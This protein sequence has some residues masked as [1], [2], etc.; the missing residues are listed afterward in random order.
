MPR[1]AQTPC[2]LTPTRGLFSTLALSC[3][4]LLLGCPL[5][6]RPLA[7]GSGPDAQVDSTASPGG[8]SGNQPDGGD[9]SGSASNVDDSGSEASAGEPGDAGQAPTLVDGCADLDGDGVADCQEGLAQNP[10]FESDTADWVADASTTLTWDSRNAW[11][12]VPSG[13]ALVAASGVIDADANGAALHAASQ[14]VPI[15]GKQL[16][17]VYANALVDPDQ[18]TQG[19]AEVDVSFY[20][21]VACSGASTSS[22]STPQP[23]DGSVGSWLSLR[24]GSVS[25]ATTKSALIRLAISLPF[26]AASFHARFDNVLVKAQSP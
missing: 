1:P 25:G 5:D 17:T 13:S 26:R 6:N 14:C 19:L 23:L 2:R 3:A 4:S 24:A 7:L 22:F 15:I 10:D 18:D 16:V 9:K 21:S 8:Q 12:D 11:G 20:D